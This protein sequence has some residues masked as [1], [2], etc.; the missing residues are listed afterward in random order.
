MF[1]VAVPSYHRSD[2]IASK[3]LAVLR[4]GGVPIS[5]I[6]VFV[7]AEEEQAYRQALPEYQV[8]VGHL[9]L[10]KQRKFIQDFFPLDTLI[11]MADDDLQEVFEASYEGDLYKPSKK[12]ILDLSDQFTQMFRRMAQEAVTICGFYPIDNLKFAL[13]NPQITTDFR[14][15]V[16]AL[17]LIKNVRD[18]ETEPQ[19][20]DS[21]EDKERTILKYIKEG[22]TLRYNHICIKT[23][24]FAEG[25]LNT[26]DRKIRHYDF[27]KMLV[28][29][30]PQF[31]R[32]KLKK[33]SN[34]ID[35]AFKRLKEQ[36][37]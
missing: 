5:D 33:R 6:Y 29:M 34:L 25:G 18:R 2:V 30:Y 20:C 31:L 24:Y 37:P 35:C 9:G 10:I 8:I 4:L 32:L 16:G 12:P 1:K 14:Y 17:Y 27:G 26:P 7:V 21:H 13:A 28:D 22:K 3:T 23:K 36:Q 15:I 19:V 11:V